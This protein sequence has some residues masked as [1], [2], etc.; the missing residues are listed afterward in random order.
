[1]VSVAINGVSAMPKT[2]AIL[3]SAL[4]FAVAPFMFSAVIPWWLTHWH[5]RPPF[6]GV[7]ASR[8]A[9]IALILAGAPGLINSFA[10]FALE[11]LGTPAPVAPTQKL[12]VTGLYRHVRNPMY[13]AVTSVIVGQAN[14]FG[15][16]RLLVLGAVFWLAS[17]IFVTTYEEPTLQRTFGTQYDTF[18]N[19]VPR[20]I[21]RLTPW[22]SSEALMP[23]NET[24]TE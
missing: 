1:M 21:P 8:V 5:F 14:L 23:H 12:V 13:I 11:G 6:F 2:T 20:W 19:N 10:R 9:G 24:F 18:R 15:D 17:H 22:R 3:G 7:E 16:A 4:F